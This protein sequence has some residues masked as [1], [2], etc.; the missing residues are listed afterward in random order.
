MWQGHAEAVRSLAFSPDG[1]W[2]ASASDDCTVKV[3][4]PTTRRIYGISPELLDVLH[5]SCAGPSQPR[6]NPLTG[7]VYVRVCVCVCSQLW[8]LTQGK[9]ITEF[10][11]H[12]AAVNMVQFHPNEHLLASGSSDRYDTL[13]SV[14][15]S[16]GPHAR[17]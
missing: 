10:R 13:N 5:P 15:T 1:K 7:S 11:A 3:P 6:S 17:L 16:S 2:L 8:D 14:R 12:A 4:T 9:I